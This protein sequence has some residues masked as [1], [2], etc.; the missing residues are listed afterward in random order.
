M[1]RGLI[2]QY[3]FTLALL[4]ACAPSRTV[5]EPAHAKARS[6]LAAAVVRTK[7]EP[8]PFPVLIP[9]EPRT[10]EGTFQSPVRWSYF[11]DRNAI[12]SSQVVG[13]YLVAV[14]EAGHVLLFDAA[15]VSL[16]GETLA[17][18]KAT[19]LGP[20]SDTE[21]LVGFAD[22][23]IGRL[24]IPGLTVDE[25][26]RVP[27]RPIWLAKGTTTSLA[28]YDDEPVSDAKRPD[29]GADHYTV[30]ILPAGR[31]IHVQNSSSFLLDDEDRLWLG[32]THGEW[33]G[34][35][36]VLELRTG[37]LKDVALPG[38]ASN[39]LGVAQIGHETWAYGGL[40]HGG[41]CSG[42]IARV[43][44]GKLKLLHYG[45]SFALVLPG[46][47]RSPRKPE[48]TIGNVIDLGD[49]LLVLS[50]K[51]FETDR[52]V[53]H[54]K[55]ICDFDLHYSSGRTDSS[56]RAYPTARTAEVIDGRVLVPTSRDGYVEL[57][58]GNAIR[59]SLPEELPIAPTRV[60]TSGTQ[61]AAQGAGDGWGFYV[62]GDWASAESRWLPPKVE[63]EQMGTDARWCNTRFFPALDG[64]LRVA[65]ERVSGGEDGWNTPAE[66]LVTG[67]VDDGTF[68]ELSR[69]RTDLRSYSVDLLPDGPLVAAGKDRELLIQD[70]GAFRPIHSVQWTASIRRNLG[71]YDK[72]WLLRTTSGPEGL[73][74]LE[75]RDGIP[76][77][78]V[79]PL[80][81]D[82]YTPETYD[83]LRLSEDTVLLATD[84]GLCTYDVPAQRCTR[85]HPAGLREVVKYLERDE[86]GRIWLGGR[87]LFWLHSNTEVRAAGPFLP[88]LADAEVRD[89]SMSAGRLA[90]ALG[91]RGIVLLDPTVL[92][93][94]LDG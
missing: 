78:T 48:C 6:P 67:R 50:N 47:D 40:G 82:D 10:A 4:G 29:R 90:V 57:R 16:I 44:P 70:Q 7:V 31:D 30:R 38:K 49:K 34:G 85:L 45:K 33:G 22:G 73:S 5:R 24:A 19:C 77:L 52:A 35:L 66:L 39:V 58:D 79:L 20:A 56:E 87:G 13:R 54:W 68:R 37:E 76:V 91:L 60:V 36:Q 25:F 41:V 28:V 62:E 18:R 17:P 12:V 63:G 53:R 26:A 2:L 11:Y 64:S 92:A 8:P 86:A 75:M 80:R 14:T 89:L 81:I 1:V 23:R 27:G 15:S 61:L 69:E 93:G 88:M 65:T 3:A 32:A 83:A 9:V 42:F 74:K 46:R 59:H 72:G 55:R 21:V 43:S 84:R 71:P 51:N 94:A